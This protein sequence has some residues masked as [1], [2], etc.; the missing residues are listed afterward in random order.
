MARSATVY[1]TADG[2]SP[3]PSSA[4]TEA[5]T[6]SLDGTTLT[7]STLTVAV[8]EPFAV[9][10]VAGSGIGAVKVGCSDAQTT[11]QG[12]A[13]GFVI[14]KAGT[15]DIVDEMSSDTLGSITVS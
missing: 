7:P 10:A 3:A 8:N 15:Y 6:M 1:F 14:T 13:I 5:N 2:K 12:V 11:V 4:I 9:K